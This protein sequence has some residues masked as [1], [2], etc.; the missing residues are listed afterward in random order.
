M[1]EAP[2]QDSEAVADAGEPGEQRSP[3]EIRRDIDQTREDLGDTVAAVAQ[4]A[5]VKAQAK[6]NSVPLA[7]GGAF[8]AGLIAVWLLRR[9]GS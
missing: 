4:K 2:R 7:V 9:R 3:E 8:A 5:D 6:S 1:D